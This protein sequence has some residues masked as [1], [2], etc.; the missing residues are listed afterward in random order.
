MKNLKNEGGVLIEF[1]HVNKKM[2]RK[3]ILQDIN[4]R[5]GYGVY[6]LLGP[7]GAG[8]TTWMR[9]MTN[10]YQV[11]DGS[12]KI[13]GIPLSKWKKQGIGYLP[14]SFGIFQELNVWETMKYFCCLKKIPPKKQKEEIERCLESVFLIDKRKEKGKRLSG[15]MVR[16]VGVAQTL[17]GHPEILLFDEPTAGLDTE[18]RMNFKNIISQYGKEETVIISTHIVDDIEACCDHVIV[19]NHGKM[20]RIGT[21]SEIR[22][23]AVEKVYEC[24]KGEEEQIQGEYVLERRYESKGRVH[25]RIL[26][27][28]SPDMKPMEPSLE[29]GYMCI[30]KGI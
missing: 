17:I 15:G 10:L 23:T 12:I 2:N 11:T 9:C 5:L 13:D 24:L 8:K 16:R 4:C 22:E 26:T 20:C 1:A 27:S 30:I 25:H 3:Y 6:G 19:M 7:N 28:E 29:D 18:E 14:Q 21:C